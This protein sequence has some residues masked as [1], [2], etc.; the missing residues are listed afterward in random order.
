MVGLEGLCARGH[1]LHRLIDEYPISV[2]RSLIEASQWNKKVD[3]FTYAQATTMAVSHA[4]DCAF[5]KGKGKVLDK[6]QK[7]L[8]KK[9]ERSKNTKDAQNKLLGAFGLPRMKDG[10]N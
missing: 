4:L 10:D 5:S 3:L 9:T 7:A 6:F 8:F 2:V 1:D